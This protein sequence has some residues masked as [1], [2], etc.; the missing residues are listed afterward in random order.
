MKNVKEKKEKNPAAVALG[1][2][3]G[4]KGGK[5]RA[6][7]LTK[8]RRHEIA[9]KAAQTRWGIKALIFILFFLLPVDVNAD[10]WTYSDTVMQTGYSLILISDW[11]QTL[12]IDSHDNLKESNKILGEHPSDDKINLY[13]ASI[14]YGHYYIAKKLDQPYRF[15][16]QLILAS[17]H[18]D[19]VQTNKRNGLYVDFNF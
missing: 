3:G 4:S 12:G 19:A 5:A 15:M 1:K 14:L 6:A 8:E 13:F 9:K 18:Y 16:W 7:K 17:H 11:N 2:L 10:E